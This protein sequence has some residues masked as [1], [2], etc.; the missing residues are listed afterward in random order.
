M[1]NIKLIKSY[2]AALDAGDIDQA[3]QYLAEQYLLLDFIQQSM[4]KSAM[5]DMWKNFR[6]AMPNLKHSLSNVRIEDNLVRATVQMS[7]TNNGKLDL[8]NMGFGLIPPTKK[9][10][11]FPNSY[12][13]FSISKDKIITERDISPKSPNRRMAGR[14]KEFDI[15]IACY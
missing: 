9:F 5:L 1:D 7:G 15:H 6:I 3:G 12:S 10:L 13:E 11:I 8:R 2:Y 4:D 14:L